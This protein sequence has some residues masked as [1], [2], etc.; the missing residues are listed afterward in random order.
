M[1][2][3]RLDE[4]ELNLPATAQAGDVL[5]FGSDAYRLYLDP[6]RGLRMARHNGSVESDHEARQREQA[7]YDATMD[8]AANRWGY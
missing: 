8:A 5:V 4:N 6:Q 3:Y 1:T 2:I 7:D